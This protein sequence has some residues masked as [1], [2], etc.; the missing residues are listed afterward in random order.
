MEEAEKRYD[1]FEAGDVEEA[2]PRRDTKETY[3]SLESGAFA[4]PAIPTSPNKDD[5]DN[6]I[7]SCNAF[8]REDS[9]I[10]PHMMRLS[11]LE[12]IKSTEGDMCAVVVD[13]PRG[14]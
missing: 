5:Y 9:H 12:K 13:L 6:K 11:S 10:R 2:S 8:R 1:K 4:A 7:V 14:P 3:D